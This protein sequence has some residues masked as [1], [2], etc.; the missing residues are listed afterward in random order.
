MIQLPI[1]PLEGL[2]TER[3]AFRRLVPSDVEW[4]MEYINNAEAIRFMP[5]KV[6]S[7]SDAGTMI[8]RSLDR[9]ASDGSG[10]NAIL[11]RNGDVPLGQCGLLTQEV[12][13]APELEVGYHFLPR[14]WGKGY[15]SEA[16]IACKEH[17]LELGL[18]PSVI[19]L[20][21]PENHR[22]Q[23]VAMRNGMVREKLTL[24]RGVPAHVWRVPSA[25]PGG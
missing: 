13:G 9:Y 21:D 14:Y 2:T 8:Q 3:L 17:A 10:L 24:H 23:A 18:A 12:D 5:F 15:A 22:S 4:W 20:I 16:A 6:G 25:G 19:S 11:L 1:P 7:R